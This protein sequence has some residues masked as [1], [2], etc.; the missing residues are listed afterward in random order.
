[1]KLI[2]R[3]IPSKFVFDLL[4][5]LSFWGSI[6]SISLLGCLIRRFL[7]F[8]NPS[9]PPSP[10]PAHQCQSPE[11]HFAVDI[12]EMNSRILSSSLVPR[13]IPLGSSKSITLAT[14]PEQRTLEIISPPSTVVLQAVW[15]FSSV[16]EEQTQKLLNQNPGIFWRIACWSP[17]KTGIWYLVLWY[18]HSCQ[19]SATSFRDSC[20]MNYAPSRPI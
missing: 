5:K 13:I 6:H 15:N 8:R 9:G 16:S 19:S 2:I 12:E 20:P 1:M 18:W 7:A 14:K 4:V 3:K 10:Y 11:G 17:T